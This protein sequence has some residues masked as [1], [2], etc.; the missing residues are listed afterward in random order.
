MHDAALDGHEQRAQPLQQRGGREELRPEGDVPRACAGDLH[1][2]AQRGKQQEAGEGAARRAL[3]E[4]EQ[5]PDRLYALPFGGEE[6]EEE[7]QP[8]QQRGGEHEVIVGQRVQ[9]AEERQTA[10]MRIAHGVLHAQ[11]DQR[12]ESD[13]LPEVIELRVHHA[14]G[15]KGIEHR[16]E[17]RVLLL[18]QHAAEPEEAEGEPAGVLEHGHEADGVRER[19]LR[20]QGQRPDE[21]AA[22]GVKRIA[23]QSGRAQERGKAVRVQSGAQDAPRFQQE[24]QLL[25]D[26]V[27]AGHKAPAEGQDRGGKGQKRQNDPQTEDLG[28]GKMP[29]LGLTQG[30]LHSDPRFC[31]E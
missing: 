28:A 2:E 6:P 25:L 4:E 26:E 10:G 29:L 19:G 20:Q 16:A 5:D 17:Q 27:A 31:A 30:V 7:I 13:D 11:E 12:K 22:Q 9:A 1:H 3:K 21:G 8:G 18:C 23:A 15:G 14:E 24:G